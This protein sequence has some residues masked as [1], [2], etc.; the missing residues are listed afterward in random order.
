LQQIL[1][2]SYGRRN[3]N[4]LGQAVLA[5]AVVASGPAFA[6]WQTYSNDKLGYSVEFPGKPVEGSG[7]YR[8]DL[9]VDAPTHYAALKDGD[10]SFVALEIDTGQPEEGTALMGEFEYWLTQIGDIALDSVSRLNV[11]MQYGRFLTV[12]CR[13]DVVPEGP[14]QTARARE[15]LHN[16]AGIECPD[17]ARLTTNLFFTQGRLYAI[18]GIAQ[19]ANAKASSAP[20]RFANSLD[21]VGANAEHAKAVLERLEAARKGA[22]KRNG[23]NR[24]AVPAP[25]R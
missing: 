4:H 21:W 20:G 19:G 16:A 25:S 1:F 13:D 7:A 14:H 24:P 17:G 18:T 5:I 3:L 12:D 6:A 2:G 11:G 23:D 15:I 9:V 10:T 8:T 22:E